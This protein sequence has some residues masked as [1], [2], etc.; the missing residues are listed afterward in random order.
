MFGVALIDCC[1]VYFLTYEWRN[2]RAIAQLDFAARSR[3]FV[4]SAIERLQAQR[5][6]FSCREAYILIGG[7]WVGFTVMVASNWPATGMGRLLIREACL[8][9]L[10]VVLRPFGNYL[11]AKRWNVEC[12]P[13]VERLTAL[14]EAT[15]ERAE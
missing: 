13:L 15:Q 12:R 10:A 5:H 6:P 1:V 8:T 9:A 2:Q 4:C 14:L 11:R 7:C 3:D